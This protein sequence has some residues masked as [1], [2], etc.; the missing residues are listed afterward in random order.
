MFVSST[1]EVCA[2][3]FKDQI[4][5]HKITP[6]LCPKTPIQETNKSGAT[7]FRNYARVDDAAISAHLYTPFVTSN[8]INKRERTA[9]MI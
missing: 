6:L 9:H 2:I 5:D 1:L 4:S 3:T 8:K 7:H